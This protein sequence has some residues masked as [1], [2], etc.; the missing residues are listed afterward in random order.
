MWVNFFIHNT[1]S[2][3]YRETQN[4]IVRG[5]SRGLYE[6]LKFNLYYYNIHKI[7]KTKY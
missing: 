2:P 4:C 3:S 6:F 1:K 7:K 5:F